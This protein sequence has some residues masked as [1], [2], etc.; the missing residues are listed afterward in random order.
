MNK[1]LT[2]SQIDRQNILNNEIALKEF[3][4][5]FNVSGI[6]FEGQYR[7]TKEMVAKFFEV[8]IRT[9]ERYINNNTD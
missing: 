2:T 9:I 1:D 5:S 8:D 3:Y 4:N 6:I 7:Y